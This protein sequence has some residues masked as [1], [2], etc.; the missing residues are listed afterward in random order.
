MLSKCRTFVHPTVTHLN[1]NTAAIPN[2]VWNG[3]RI[4]RNLKISIPRILR[5]LPTR[6]IHLRLRDRQ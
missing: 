5:N 6:Q 2:K 1:Q 3:C 4:F